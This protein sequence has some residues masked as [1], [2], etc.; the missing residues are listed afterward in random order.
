MEAFKL[1]L[2][3]LNRLVLLQNQIGDWQNP[4]QR[5]FYGP[6]ISHSATDTALLAFHNLPI[7]KPAFS[8]AI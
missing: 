3:S 4:P 8:N 7:G 1:S 6:R 5:W 2:F